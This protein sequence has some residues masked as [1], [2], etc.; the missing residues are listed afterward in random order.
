MVEI[1][2]EPFTDLELG[3]LLM[4]ME[5]Y[6]EIKE[7]GLHVWGRRLY[8]RLYIIKSKMGYALANPTGND[9]GFYKDEFT[10][11]DLKILLNIVC[12]EGLRWASE[13]APTSTLKIGANNMLVISEDFKGLSMAIIMVKL[14]KRLAK[15]S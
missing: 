11:V 3:W 5:R 8:E 7:Y 12:T 6:F 10:Y 14:K 9:D 13:E 15:F 2:S 4:L 1:N